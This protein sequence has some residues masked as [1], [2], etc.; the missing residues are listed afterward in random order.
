MRI[1]KGR[2]E[3]VSDDKRI[4]LIQYVTDYLRVKLRWGH[5]AARLEYNY[6]QLYMPVNRSL[7]NLPLV[8]CD[9]SAVRYT[10]DRGQLRIIEAAGKA[11]SCSS[12]FLHVT[13]IRRNYCIYPWTIEP[14]SLWARDSAR[15]RSIQTFNDIEPN[16]SLEVLPLA[17]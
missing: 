17:R 11:S 15:Y 4:I 3:S 5:Q 6:A 7:S 1:K 10:H 16:S 13:M 2:E 12:R 14:D 8:P 9:I